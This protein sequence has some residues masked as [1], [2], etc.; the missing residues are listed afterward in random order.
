[1]DVA[2]R[3]NKRLLCCHYHHVLSY[4]AFVLNM[5]KTR[6]RDTS[7]LGAWLKMLWQEKKE[8]KIKAEATVLNNDDDSFHH[9]YRPVIST[10]LPQ[11]FWSEKQ[12]NQLRCTS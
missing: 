5:Q 6:K 2:R 8:I 4:C 10:K 7:R 11:H 3:E 1:M 12:A 9:F